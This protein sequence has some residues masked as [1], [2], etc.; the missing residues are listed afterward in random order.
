[1]D[2]I[3]LYFIFAIIS[4][5]L[6]ISIQELFFIFIGRE[7]QVLAIAMVI[8]TIVS[9]VFKYFMDKF[10]VFNS[11]SETKKEEVK[12]VFLY[13]FFSVFTTLI[14]MVV[15]FAFHISFS[16]QHKEELG[17]MLG[18]TIGY[19]VKYIIDKKITFKREVSE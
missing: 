10:Y 8:A 12:K 5:I 2:K 11:K 7:S 1:M 14:Y 15:E 19:I 4:I 13:G 17:A 18:L 6:N 16:F 9:F 3:V